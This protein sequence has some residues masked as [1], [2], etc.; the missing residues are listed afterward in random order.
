MT[1]PL[2]T[3][4]LLADDHEL[5]RSGLRMLLDAQ[6][7]IEVVAEASDGADA[8]RQ[9][10]RNPVDL[11][12]LDVSMP[13]L[14]GLQAAQE[15]RKRQPDV[16]IL[17]LSVHDNEQYLFAALNAGAAGYVLKTAASQDLVRA[18]RATMRGE[19]F[20]YPPAAAA[21]VREHGGQA[22][23]IAATGDRLTPRELEVLKLIAEAHSSDAIADTLAISRRTVDHHRASILRKLGMRG[24]VELTRYAIRRGLIEP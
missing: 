9:C 5:V 12:L 6:P 19:L 23:R 14:T 21:L 3:K 24:R 10:E 11:A 2:K 15:L 22:E 20:V 16:R 4:V 8:L 1:T 13:R 7:D 17:M 18:I